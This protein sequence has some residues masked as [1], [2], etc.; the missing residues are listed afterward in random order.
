LLID[1]HVQPGAKRTEIAGMHGEALKLRVAGR[2]VEG[3]A[4]RELIC[5][6]A[7][8]LGTAPTRVSIRLGENGRRKLLAVDAPGA[9]PLLLLKDEPS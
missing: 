2:A 8:K 4:N 7:R 9:D 3:Q 6:L 5:Y 1:L